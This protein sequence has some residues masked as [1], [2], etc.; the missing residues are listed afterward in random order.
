M[1]SHYMTSWLEPTTNFGALGRAWVGMKVAGAPRFDEK[2][3]EH[4]EVLEPKLAR[5]AAAGSTIEALLLVVTK[6]KRN[7]HAWLPPKLSAEL[8]LASGGGWQQVFGCSL[9]RKRKRSAA[10][11]SKPLFGQVWETIGRFARRPGVD[12]CRLEA[13][14]GSARP[15]CKQ[16]RQ[17]GEGLEPDI[18][19]SRAGLAATREAGDARAEALAGHQSYFPSLVHVPCVPWSTLRKKGNSAARVSNTRF[20]ESL[21]WS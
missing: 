18:A 11:H 10:G 16:P 19:Q 9:R 15:P 14:L 5:V 6:A 17:A 21:A 2:L 1:R 3:A 8:L 13:P 20:V 7:G 4:R 12:D